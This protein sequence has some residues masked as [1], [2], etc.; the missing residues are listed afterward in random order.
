MKSI[1]LVILLGSVL[2]VGSCKKEDK[3]TI[4][5]AAGSTNEL[6]QAIKDAGNGGTV[7][8]TAGE[9]NE[10]VF[11][12]VIDRK[13]TIIGEDGAVLK[14]GTN[15]RATGGTVNYGIHV[16]N[17]KGVT[18]DNVDIQP[19]NAQGGLAIYVEKSSGLVMQNGTISDF[20]YGI[21]VQESDDVLIDRNEIVSFVDFSLFPVGVTILNGLRAK[22]T[23]NTFTNHGFG[24]W[25]CDKDGEAYGNT[26]SGNAVGIILCKV[27]ENDPLNS[28]L[29]PDGTLQG[30]EVPC[31]N[32]KVHDNVCIGNYDNGIM[33]IDGSTSN[34]VYDNNATG[35]GLSPLYGVAADIEI[36]NESQL[37]GFVSP[38]VKN[39][40]VDATKFPATR[41]KNCAPLEGNT[42]TGGVMVDVIME[43]CR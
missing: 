10:C 43:G 27:P 28:F 17:T 40:T 13:V 31:T 23:N 20:Q 5:L 2:L 35:N 32:W 42:V 41:V 19:C 38:T 18:I 30:A 11:P 33:I 3:K 15:P 22:V 39:N 4:T 36:F 14:L 29:L 8:L 37:F 16:K 7:L 24:F 26:C 25:A 9:H 12:L 6:V 34:Q 21:A 1:N